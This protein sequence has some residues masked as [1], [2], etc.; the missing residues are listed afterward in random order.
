MFS[1]PWLICVPPEYVL[2]VKGPE[3]KIPA[4]FSRGVVVKPASVSV[5]VPVLINVPPTLVA[6][7]AMLPLTVNVLPAMVPQKVVLAPL[8]PTVSVTGKPSEDH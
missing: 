8:P 5:P 3:A 2:P 6:I 1:V 7:T 4:A